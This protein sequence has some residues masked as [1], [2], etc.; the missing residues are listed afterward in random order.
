[1][2]DRL[3]RIL[4]RV[5]DWL[6]YE[7]AKNGALVALNGLVAGAILTWST[8]SSKIVSVSLGCSLALLLLSL[9][10]AL[11]SFYPVVKSDQLDRIAP[12]L[13]TLW[14][15]W[16]K[17]KLGRSQRE[18]KGRSLLFFVDIAGRK[19]DDYLNALRTAVDAKPGMP[20]ESDY[21]HQ[22]VE[23]SNIALLKLRLFEVA[24]LF[25]FLAFICAA[26]AAIARVAGW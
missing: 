2:E 1:V 5:I 26:V 7:E 11:V 9:L 6:K 20:L 23:C 10:I 19:A 15:N 22:I 24:F 8:G 12:V 4:N 3:E 16:L 18:T 17:E 21:A 25:A 14:R 13:R